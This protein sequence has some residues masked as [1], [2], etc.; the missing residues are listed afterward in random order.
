[1][2]IEVGGKAHSLETRLQGNLEQARSYLEQATSLFR[3]LG[4]MKDAEKLERLL[5]E[6][7]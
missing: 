1:M 5:A 2:N 3:E 6:N 4:A 7:G